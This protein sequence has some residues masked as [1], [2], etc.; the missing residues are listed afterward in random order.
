MKPLKPIKQAQHNSRH[1]PAAPQIPSGHLYIKEPEYTGRKLKPLRVETAEEMIARAN[2][3]PPPKS[4]ARIGSMEFTSES[5]VLISNDGWKGHTLDVSLRLAHRFAY[6]ERR[7][8]LYMN[9]IIKADALSRKF[10][11]LTGSTHKANGLLHI[12]TAMH[13][14]L[15]EGLASLM[16]SIIKEGIEV[17]IINSWEWG[18]FTSREK[19]YLFRTIR[20]FCNESK[21]CIIIFSS[22]SANA[23]SPGFARQGLIGFLSHLA[24]ININLRQ[25]NPLLPALYEGDLNAPADEVKPTYM[26]VVKE[27]KLKREHKGSIEIND[28][29][30]VVGTTEA[31]EVHLVS[32]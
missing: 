23:I 27:K 6:S 29:G 5:L 24:D 30:E 16:E 14:A 9:S 8:T 20:E 1:I 18:A 13:G 32:V 7:K 15:G 25:E 10:K 21:L 3:T 4:L 17:L 26:T 22:A 2:S 12:A 19:Q 11:D 31:P 28:L